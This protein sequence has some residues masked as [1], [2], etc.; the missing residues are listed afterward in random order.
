MAAL[1]S[2]IL[3]ATLLAPTIEESSALRFRFLLN[4]LVAISLY[5]SEK[6]HFQRSIRNGQKSARWWLPLIWIGAALG[7]LF[8][9]ETLFV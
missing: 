8:L 7:A 6:P 1:S 9:V 2:L 4:G 3:V 5:K